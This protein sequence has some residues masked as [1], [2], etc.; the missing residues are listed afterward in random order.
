M[1]KYLS[2]AITPWSEKTR[3]RV[4]LAAMILGAAI[5]ITT[6]QPGQL[7]A[8][9]VFRLFNGT[10]FE[11][12]MTVGGQA[13]TVTNATMKAFSTDMAGVILPTGQGISQSVVMTFAIPFVQTPFC[14]VTDA[15]GENSPEGLTVLPT[16]TTLTIAGYANKE[17]LGYLCLGT[18]QN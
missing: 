3:N 18:V 13:P 7:I 10:V 9:S 15:G 4:W 2:I 6:T 5:V 8:Q 17:P 14:V 1:K 16:T 11:N 12:H